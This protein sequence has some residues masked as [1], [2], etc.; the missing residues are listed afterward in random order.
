MLVF[1][2]YQRYLWYWYLCCDTF[3][4]VGVRAMADPAT[5]IVHSPNKSTSGGNG[6]LMAGRTWLPLS[7]PANFT[8]IAVV[9]TVAAGRLA[10]AVPLFITQCIA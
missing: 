10:T 1:R 3:V 2:W 5:L 7:R 4:A 9:Y 6:Q 8:L